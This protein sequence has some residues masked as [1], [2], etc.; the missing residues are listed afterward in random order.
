MKYCFD[1][2]ANA[3]PLIFTIRPARR[4]AKALQPHLGCCCSP[5]KMKLCEFHILCG[6]DLK[7][8]LMPALLLDVIKQKR[9]EKNNYTHGKKSCNLLPQVFKN[10]KQK[11]RF[12][13]SSALVLIDLFSR[14]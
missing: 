9:K 1:L 7:M 14:M 2:N 13:F 8:S 4:K 12:Q 3:R 10:A 6:L 11:V 5:R